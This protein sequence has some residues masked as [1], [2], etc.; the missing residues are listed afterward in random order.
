MEAQAT[1]PV[2]RTEVDPSRIP[3]AA[4]VD[5][6]RE[7]GIARI[8]A[9]LAGIDATAATLEP[10]ARASAHRTASRAKDLAASRR[11]Q[12][13]SRNVSAA[14]L[15]TAALLLSAGCGGGKPASTIG[16]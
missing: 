2:S 10:A 4:R 6:L 16:K 9:T 1:N 5:R 3:T 13:W 12:R 8:R 7:H 14:V 11:W 15:A